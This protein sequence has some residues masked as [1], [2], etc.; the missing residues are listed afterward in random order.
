MVLRLAVLICL[1]FPRLAYCLDCGPT[2]DLFKGQC[3]NGA[4]VI[5]TSSP[6]PSPSPVAVPTP[7]PGSA[8]APIV[9][10]P[11]SPM[12]IID[13]PLILGDGGQRWYR[14]ITFGPGS[15]K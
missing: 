5:G 1:I 11:C 6:V 10:P 13:I 14:F 7:G 4:C 12:T 3:V 2:C 8:G 9:C 15:S